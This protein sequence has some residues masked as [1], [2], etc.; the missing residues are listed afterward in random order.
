MKIDDETSTVQLWGFRLAS[1]WKCGRMEVNYRNLNLELGD[2]DDAMF[3]L[4]R[5][6]IVKL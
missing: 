6:V 3:T 2:I 5:Y 4:P 1:P